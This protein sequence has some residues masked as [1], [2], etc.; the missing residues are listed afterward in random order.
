M[1][2][3]KHPLWLFCLLTAVWGPFQGFSQSPGGSSRS[4]Q[5]SGGSSQSSGGLSQSALS[6]QQRLLTAAARWQGG[7]LSDTNYLHAVDSV[8]PQLLNDDSLAQE[9]STYR[10]IA[11]SSNDLEKYQV[12][13]YRYMAVFSLN[14]HKYGSAIYYSERNNEASVRL[15]F[16]EK[17]GIA[18]SDLFAISVYEIDRDFTRLLAKYNTLTPQ[19]EHIVATIAAGRFSGEQG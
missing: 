6:P 18:H 3:R 15:G 11:F 17:E 5:P 7:Q 9:L 2:M 13:Y 14:K 4:S 8:A 16:F 10:Q 19:L 12:R 1:S